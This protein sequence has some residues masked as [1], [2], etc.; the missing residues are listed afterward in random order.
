M[1][2]TPRLAELVFHLTGC[3]PRVASSAVDAVPADVDDPLMIVARAMCSIRRI[4]LTQHVD[5]R[6]SNQIHAN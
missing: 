1:D 6:E 3:S 4:D 2:H 5:L